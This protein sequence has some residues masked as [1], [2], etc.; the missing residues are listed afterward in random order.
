MRKVVVRYTVTQICE[1]EIELDD[2]LAPSVID[3]EDWNELWEHLDPAQDEVEC[4][5]EITEVYEIKE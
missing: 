1:R 3:F 5:S 2:D 4:D